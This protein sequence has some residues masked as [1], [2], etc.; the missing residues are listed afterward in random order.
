M[1]FFLNINVIFFSHWDCLFHKEYVQCLEISHKKAS[2]NSLYC[3]TTVWIILLCVL[4]DLQ[5]NCIFLL[6]SF[7]LSPFFIFIFLFELIVG[8]LVWHH[9]LFIIPLR[10]SKDSVHSAKSCD[11]EDCQVLCCPPHHTTSVTWNVCIHFLHISWS[12]ST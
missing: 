7:F 1:F 10:G 9:D 4:Y 2:W 8:W 6:V 11:I 5:L 3:Q 12:K